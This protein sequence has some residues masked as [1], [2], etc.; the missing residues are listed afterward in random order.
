MIFCKDLTEVGALLTV[1]AQGHRTD[2]V[3]LMPF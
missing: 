3:L 2:R 1:L